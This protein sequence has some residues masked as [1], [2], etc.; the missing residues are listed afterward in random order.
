MA[1]RRGVTRLM[2]TTEGSPISTV[3]AG[4]RS[5]IRVFW[6]SRTLT[7]AKAGPARAEIIAASTHTL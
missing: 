6:S 2:S 4:A 3:P 1:I 7:V 5:S